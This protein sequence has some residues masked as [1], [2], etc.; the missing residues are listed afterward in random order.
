MKKQLRKI[1]FIAVIGIFLLPGL[2]ATARTI[3]GVELAEKVEVAGQQLVLNG[4]GVRKKFFFTIYAA[5]LY[6]PEKTTDAKTAITSDVP[7]RIVMQFVYHKVE[8][9]KLVKAWNN[10]F[11]KNSQE[12]LDQLRER[13]DRFNSF[14]TGA[15]L[16]GDRAVFT[17]LPGRGTVVE[18][19]GREKGTIPGKDF[20]QALW[21]IWLGENPA[22]DDLKAAMLGQ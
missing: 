11:F 1:F 20:M 5:G 13:I 17:Y 16:K 12:K 14:F 22:D 19:N 2:P 3:K 9:E 15:A 6:L 18:I 10:G 7:K 8:G 4:A 21:A